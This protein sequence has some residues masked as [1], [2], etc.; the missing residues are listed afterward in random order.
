MLSDRYVRREKPGLKIKGGQL[1]RFA[2]GTEGDKRKSTKGNR[3]V[4]MSVEELEA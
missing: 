3:F 2:M 4:D 1:P